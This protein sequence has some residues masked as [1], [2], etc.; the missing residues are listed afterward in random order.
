M[1]VNS[2]FRLKMRKLKYDDI[3]MQTKRSWDKSPGLSLFL[4]ITLERAPK[5]WVHVPNY[6]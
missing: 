3:L 2:Y 4:N 6:G 5:V 1:D